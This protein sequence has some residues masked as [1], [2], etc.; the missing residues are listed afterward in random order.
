MPRHRPGQH[1]PLDICAE[2]DEV[3]DLVTVVD[4]NDVLFDDRSLIEILSDVVRRCAHQ[5]HAALARSPIRC[6]ADKGRQERVMDV[7][8]WATHLGQET[9]RQNLHIARQHY[10]VDVAAQ[11]FELA[12]LG[13]LAD[14][15]R[16]RYVNERHPEG[17]HLFCQFGMVADHHGDLHLQLSAA[18][19]P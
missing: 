10:Q 14:V 17:P 3:V 13:L 15:L 8:Q 2:P 4:A 11:Q 19:S 12:A 16:L 18:I 1:R 5:F 6:R 9:G 7:D